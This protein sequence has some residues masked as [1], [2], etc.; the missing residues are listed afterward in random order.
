MRLRVSAALKGRCKKEWIGG[1]PQH[2][3][4]PPPASGWSPHIAKSNM[5][6]FCFDR[7]FE[8]V[9]GLFLDFSTKRIGLKE[10]WEL[11]WHRNWNPNNDPPPDWKTEAPWMA[12][13]KDYWVP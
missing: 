8:H 1:W 2:S 9:N 6:R 3:D 10:L 4:D 13:M 5:A 7:H 11:D 12:H